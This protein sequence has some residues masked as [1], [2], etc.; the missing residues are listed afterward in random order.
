MAEIADRAVRS[1]RRLRGD[2]DPRPQ[3]KL[4]AG[5]LD[6]AVPAS[7]NA[8]LV[9]PAAAP[10]VLSPS[11][12]ICGVSRGAWAAAA[13]LYGVLAAALALATWTATPPEPWPATP[14]VYKV[15][16]EEPPAPPA[17]APP[18]APEPPSAAAEQPP[19]PAVAEPEPEPPPPPPVALAEPTP[20]PLPKPPPAKPVPPRHH[21]AAPP[22]PAPSPP[23]PSPPADQQ[24]AT[25]TPPALPAA[26]ILPPQPISGLGSNR[27]PDYPMAAKQR[28]QQGRVVL[29]VDVSAA[30]K[31]LSVTVLSTSGYSLLDKAALAAVEHWQ[32]RPATQ[33][34][35]AVAGAADVPI[36]FRLEE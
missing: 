6:S 31:A 11:S 29:R 2:S 10:P 7:R 21:A 14:T 30:G 35:I 20:Q 22:R 18:A 33:A 3:L 8:P 4:I 28:G 12:D 13:I 1:T 19:E 26:P 36:Q 17:P 23:T 34:G 16:F 5:A 32:F 27:K 24:V 9:A 25:L 15:V